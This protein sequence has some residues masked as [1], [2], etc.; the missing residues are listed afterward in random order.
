VRRRGRRA[1]TRGGAGGH[2]RVRRGGAL[3]RG[4]AARCDVAAPLGAAGGAPRHRRRWARGAVAVA[5]FLAGCGGAAREPAAT[6]VP[7]RAPVERTPAP[8]AVPA[9][10]TVHFRASDGEP[11]EALYTPA[12]RHAPAILLLHEIRGRPE[13]WDELVPYLHQAGF[14]TLAYQSRGTPVEKDRLPDA[15]GALRWLQRRDDVD[16]R[17]I[18]LVGASIGASTTVLAMATKARGIAAAAVA[19]S[20]PDTPD[21]ADLQDAGRYHPHDILFISDASEAAAPAGMLDGAKRSKAL[22]SRG[23]GHGVRLLAEPQVRAAL[24]DW[25]RERVSR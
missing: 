15:V 11:V 17:R 13:Q 18:G 10:T 5:L 2:R 20:P 14:A 25:L 24:L 9:P 23:P 1:V 16:Q 19:L 3:R 4:G 7:T 8:P 12:G 22:R 21:V 6:P